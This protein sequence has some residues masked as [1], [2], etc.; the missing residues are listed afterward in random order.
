MFAP[1]GEQAGLIPEVALC[2]DVWF[3]TLFAIVARG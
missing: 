1:E 2:V 3:V